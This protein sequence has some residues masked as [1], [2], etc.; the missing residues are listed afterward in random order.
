MKM[1]LVV[2]LTL[3]ALVSVG[4]SSLLGSSKCTWG[5]S[6]W[7]SHVSRAKE[8]Q[9]VE[10]CL[11]SVWLKQKDSSKGSNPQCELCE[12]VI[13]TVRE[14]LKTLP[15][16]QVVDDLKTIC[17]HLPFNQ[18][19]KTE[20]INGMSDVDVVIKLLESNMTAKGLCGIFIS[21]SGF[22]DN[23]NHQNKPETN[24]LVP[25][26]EATPVNAGNICT[27]CVSFITDIKNLLTAPD[28]ESQLIGMLKQ[29]VCSQLGSV[30]AICNDLVDTYVPQ[31]LSVL[32]SYIDPTVTCSAVGFCTGEAT[33]ELRSKFNDMKTFVMVVLR[34]MG[35][36]VTTNALEC[37]ACKSI[38]ADL[39]KMA[40]DPTIQR[41]VVDFVEQNVC[42]HLGELA[43]LCKQTVEDNYIG[44]FQLI[45]GSLIDDQVCINLGMCPSSLGAAKLQ[46][47]TIECEACTALIKAL[48]FLE[49]SATVQNTIKNFLEN[50]VCP[51]LGSSAAQCKMDVDMY[52]TA[53]FQILKQILNAGY[54]C[55]KMNLCAAPVPMVT[56]NGALCD[57]CNTI[58]TEVDSLLKNQEFQ[59]EIMSQLDSII[60]TRLSGNLIAECKN[61]VD[62]YT[63]FVLDLLA[64]ELNPAT[65]CK[66]LGVC[67]A[68]QAV[69][70]TPSKA[71]IKTIKADSTCVFCEFSMREAAKF[72]NEKSTKEE[73]RSVLDKMCNEISGIKDECETAL[74][75]FFDE[76][77]AALVA[78]VAPEEICSYIG[79]CSSKKS[80]KKVPPKASPRLHVVPLFKEALPTKIFNVENSKSSNKC[81]LCEMVMTYVKQALKEKATAE[82]IKA[83]LDMACGKIPKEYQ[84][85]CEDYVNEYSD[86]LVHWLQTMDD[87]YMICTKLHFCAT[88]KAVKTTGPKDNNLYFMKHRIVT[89]KCDQGP[90][91]WCSSRAAANI[92][93]KENYCLKRNL[94]NV[95]V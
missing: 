11:Q 59:A 63:P 3:I 81:V 1:R 10:H 84:Q 2:S 83:A 42:A 43:D 4:S 17:D 86:K 24:S 14:K 21:C 62:E 30:E 67:S 54:L 13:N 72:L 46:L 37:D 53:V 18:T 12:S 57:V 44:V 66:D 80:L 82:D 55:G 92:C 50:Y 35:I 65:F 68:K 25:L 23:T 45:A 7:C 58:A 64:G 94:I 69:K 90:K 28:T 8:C 34:K 15:V 79:L 56:S 16:D 48:S 70:T 20:C 73:V 39:R 27:D 33:L 19:Y 95:L 36:H 22:E 91:Y 78:K 85:M 26:V 32:A 60:C 74:N 52:G 31:G 6:Y 47:G 38:A 41:K 9:A 71:V 75:L 76:I 88:P 89:K 5:P 40:R 93:G 51:R 49:S 77:Y 29:I 61:F 87:P